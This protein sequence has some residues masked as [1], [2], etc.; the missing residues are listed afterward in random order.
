MLLFDDH[1]CSKSLYNILVYYAIFF[2]TIE[3]SLGYSTGCVAC[4]VTICLPSFLCYLALPPLKR[5]SKLLQSHRST[6]LSH[7]H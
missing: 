6:S 2:P 4:H 3:T 7:L 5:V 1:K